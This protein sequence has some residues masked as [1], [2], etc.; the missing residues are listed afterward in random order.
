LVNDKIGRTCDI[1]EIFMA[2]TGGSEST[3]KTINYDIRWTDRRSKLALPEYR[4]EDLSLEKK[5]LFVAIKI[6]NSNACC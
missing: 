4:S 2:F 1:T 3:T 6:S 5:I